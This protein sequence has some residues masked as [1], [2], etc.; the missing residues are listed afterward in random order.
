MW[1]HCGILYK[2]S[3][4]ETILFPNT[5]HSGSS[6]EHLNSANYEH[7]HSIVKTCVGADEVAMYSSL[8]SPVTQ[9]TNHDIRRIIREIPGRLGHEA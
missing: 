3:F 7:V 9:F 4:Y 6:I 2:V 5:D 1:L 8:Q